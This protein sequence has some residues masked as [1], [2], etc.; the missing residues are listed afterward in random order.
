LFDELTQI[1]G[2]VW[3]TGADPSLFASLQGRAE[4]F[5]GDAWAG[6]T[7]AELTAPAIAAAHIAECRRC[8]NIEF[9]E[10]IDPRQQRNAVV[11][12]SG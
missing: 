1:G 9:V 2:Q 4:I 10:R 5:T 8:G 7:R 12:P 3:M 6:S 11:L